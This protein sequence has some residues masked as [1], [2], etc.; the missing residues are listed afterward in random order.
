MNEHVLSL[1][2]SA[3]CS[4][5]LACSCSFCPMSEDAYVCT[6]QRIFYLARSVQFRSAGYTKQKD[7]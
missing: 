7:G 2:R 5:D 6:G 4:F 3:A 1:L